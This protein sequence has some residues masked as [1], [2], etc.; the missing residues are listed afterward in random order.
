MGPHLHFGLGSPTVS[1]PNTKNPI[2]EGLKQ[3]LY[4]KLNIIEDG[5]SGQKI[6]LLGTGTDGTFGGEN[7]VS[8]EISLKICRYI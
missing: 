5:M 7:E 2:L 4:G 3:P 8:S 6:N 1:T